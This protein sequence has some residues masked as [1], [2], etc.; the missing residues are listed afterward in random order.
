M[1]GCEFV[2]TLIEKLRA[3]LDLTSADVDLAVTELLSNEVNDELKAEFLTAL[4]QKGETAEEIVAFV[5]SLT[6]RAVDP[7]ID[8]KQMS[9]PMVDICGTGGDGLSL[10]NVSTAAMFVVAAGGAVVAKHGNRRVTSSCG[11]A[12]VLEQL[13]IA[14]DLTPDQLSE[15][16][17]RY[18][19]G[20]IFART[21]H[22]AFAALAAMRERLARQK[23]RTIFNLLGP[24]LNPVRPSRQLIGVFEPRLTVVFADVLQQMKSERAWIVH[25]LGDGGVGMDDIS[26]S[27]AT[28]VAELVDGK[29][30]SAVL[31][32][33][34]L[35]V[36][37]ASV[38]ELKGGDARENA[39]TI[40]GILSGKVLG[41]KRE[42]TVVNAAG[43]F[44]VAGRA[45]D[46]K[47]GIELAREEIDSGRALEKLRALQSFQ[48]KSAA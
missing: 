13:G 7:M 11:S 12:D 6:K 1:A 20:F 5:Q 27:G 44:V 23:T 40:D 48:P 41:A 42:M 45:R 15:S 4:H 34:W 18:G 47:E 2:K 28:T 37:R 14:I 19:L 25:G 36:P 21:Y 39:E 8:P 31:D 17:K 38:S 16:L 3:E 22:P 35:G 29:M 33:S 30:N 9:G 46:L 24:L 10:F 32:V 43:G 26:I